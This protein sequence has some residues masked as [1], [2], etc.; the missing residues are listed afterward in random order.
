MKDKIGDLAIKAIALILLAYSAT[1]SLDFIGL[2]L[3]PGREIMAFF[4]LGALDGGL[5]AWIAAYQ[6]K[7]AGTWQRTIAVIMIVVDFIGIVATFTLDALYNTGASGLTVALA[8]Q[9]MQAAVIA[10]SLIIAANIG[11]AVAHH[12]TNPESLRQHAEDEA[13]TGVEDAAIELIKRDAPRL[14]A[15]VAPQIASAWREN[16]VASYAHKVKRARL[17]K[18]DSVDADPN[19][20]G[21]Q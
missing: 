5:L 16:T 12:L 6:S 11:A 4:A 14:A 21:P 10:I 19:P 2:T 3:P 7:T 1:R 9:T 17:P 15:E 18:P 8:P 13:R 20:T